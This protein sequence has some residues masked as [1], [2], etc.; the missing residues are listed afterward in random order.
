M[1]GIAWIVAGILCGELA[2][3]GEVKAPTDMDAFWRQLQ[4]AAECN[5]KID[6]TDPNLSSIFNTDGGKSDFY[7][8]KDQPF[9]VFGL[10]STMISTFR[11]LSGSKPDR[12]VTAINASMTTVKEKTNI[13]EPVTTPI[14]TLSVRYGGTQGVVEIVCTHTKNPE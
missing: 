11:D 4:E 5:L 2:N 1:K 14:G 8:S 12:F 7:A 6:S 9:S 13:D 3:A 10:Q